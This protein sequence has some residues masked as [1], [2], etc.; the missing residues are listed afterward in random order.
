[1]RPG[2][3]FT[4]PGTLWRGETVFCLGSGDSLRRIERELWAR[5]PEHGHVLAVNSSIKTARANGIEP[6][7]LF[8]TDMN[9]FEANEVLVRSFRG[10]VF[11]VSR[12]ARAACDAVERIENTHR[13]D[14]SV[15][16][17]PMRDGRSSGHRAVSL[18][19][20]L[21]ASRVILLGYDMRI[22]PDTGRSHCHDDY[23]HTQSDLD[24]QREFI[25]SFRDWHQQAL[26]VG[27]MVLNAT[28]ETALDEFPKVR[29]EDVL[30]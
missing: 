21:G 20:M 26:A 10:R 29:L 24:Y 9:W 5:L 7:A 2:D 4:N 19:I 23:A 11:T 15:G 17:P 6:D 3:E 14:F 16:A 13:P 28:P 30:I 25:P 8:F 12:A 1:M 27:A 18:A 22:D